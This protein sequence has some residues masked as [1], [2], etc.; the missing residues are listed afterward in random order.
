MP[1]VRA[2]YINSTDLLR[3][4]IQNERDVEMGFEAQAYYDDIR[5]W[6]ILPQVMGSRLIAIIPQK[7]TDL[8]NYPSGFIYA[9]TE[10][11]AD[12]Q[13]AWEEGMYFLPFLNADVLKMKNFLPNTVW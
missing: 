3:P 11:P 1:N 4:R 10:L 13:P 5:R 6:G 7:T 12:R 2:E 8:I 9:R